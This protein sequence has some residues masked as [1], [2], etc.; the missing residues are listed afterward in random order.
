MWARLLQYIIPLYDGMG[1]QLMI[2]SQ[3][4]REVFK[5]AIPGTILLTGVTFC[6]YSMY[7]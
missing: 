5:F 3:M 7:K 1:S 4:F 6:L 2:M